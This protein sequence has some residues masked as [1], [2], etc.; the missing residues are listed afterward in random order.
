MTP[1]FP[2][3]PLGQAI[4]NSPHA[5]SCSL[6]TMRSVRGYEEKDPAITSQ[7]ANGY[8]RFVVHPDARQL[9]AHYVAT[10]PA[11]AGHTLWLTSSLAIAENLVTHLAKSSAQLFVDTHGLHGVAHPATATATYALAKTYL[12]NLGGFISSREAEDHLVR[13]GLRAAI[14]PEETFA[15]DAPA[16]IRKNLRR[17]LNTGLAPSATAVTDADIIL[18]NCGMSA[19]YAAF[20]AVADLQASRG[21]TV[22][23][24]LGW[25]YLDTIAI[26]KK[27]TAS[28]A[29]YVYI[30]DPLDFDVIARIFAAHGSRIAGVVAEI[31]TNPLLQTPDIAAISALARRHG[32]HVII[33]ASTA[34]LYNLDVLPHAGI[35]LASLTKYT[36][37][38]GDLTAGVAV[39]NPEC[40]D[41]A[42]VRRR[43]SEAAEPLYIRDAA[44]LAH[45]IASTETVLET[46]HAST[47]RVVAFLENHPAIKEVF[48]A[49]HSASRAHFEKLAR[50][51]NAT[52]GMITFTLRELGGLEKFYDR[53]RLPKGPSFGMTTTLI[54]PFMYLA[55]Y[56]LVTTPAGLAE[57]AASK[58]DPDL[59]RLCVGCEP[60]EEIIAALAE[61]LGSP[62]KK[63][64][65]QST[66]TEGPL[67]SELVSIALE[68][69]SLFGIAPRIT[70]TI[71]EYDAAKIVGMTDTQ[72]SEAMKH[73]TAVSKGH[74]FEFEGRRY[75]VKANR[76]SG[77]KGCDVTLVSKPSNYD[78]D[79]LIWILYDTDYRIAEVWEWERKDFEAA[80]GTK[81]RMSPDDLRTGKKRHLAN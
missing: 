57:L 3:L 74:D 61:A 20:R 52:G 79:V 56:D 69:G 80:H 38:A 11:L 35:A 19:I 8:P 81:T 7:L 72:Y 6:P 21:R 78:W 68:W 58:L 47:P 28:P 67:R 41:A 15:G 53:L 39:V 65:Y 73:R 5:V 37:S 30:R 76:P 42:E 26:L 55:H 44:R 63:L 77:K 12:Q 75:Q 18:T 51:A 23:I 46:I 22:W 71:S 13:L 34:S 45:E 62:S 70:D 24:Q 66:I 31:P 25:F 14:Y 1:A 54:C 2:H 4:P 43:I 36:G 16:E 60:V 48:W 33:D 64:R 32:A 9:A 50:H 27:F 10:N 17:V 40:P 59:L 49:R 29:D